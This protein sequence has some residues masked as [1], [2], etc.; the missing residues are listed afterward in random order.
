MSTGRTA[1]DLGLDPLAAIA[2]ARVL[3]VAVVD[4]AERARSLAESLADGGLPLV[5][6]TFRT[7]AAADAISVVTAAGTV[8]VGAGT[9][10]SAEQARTAIDAGAR[11]VVSPGFSTEVVEVCRAQEVPVIPGVATA[12]EAMAAAAA[13]L[14]T[15]KFF[16]AEAAGGLAMLSALHSVFP[17][18]AFVPTGGITADN[19]ADYL[20][21]PAVG[22]VGG[23]WMI[24]RSVVAAGDWDEVSRR[25]RHAVEVAGRS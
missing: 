21:H 10:L 12:S 2:V 5:E 3:P 23:S 7:P 13:G 14:D 9:V 19:L 6:V 20:A 24:E 1:T 4:D 18:T 15:M 8:L 25:T 11:F 22:A 16:P 17:D